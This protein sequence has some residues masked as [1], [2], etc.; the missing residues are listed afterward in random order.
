MKF[1]AEK[2][3]IEK[4]ILPVSIVSQNK[5]SEAS[6]DGIFIK[7]ENDNVDFFCYDLEKGIKTNMEAFVAAPGS[8]VS[9][10]QLVPIIH[11]MPDGEIT[12]SSDDNFI[13]TISCGETQVQILG[14]D[15]EKYPDMPQVKGDISFT[16]TQKQL[17]NL[18]TKTCFSLSKDDSNPLLRGSYFEIKENILTVSSIDGFRC[19]VRTEKS[20]TECP[21]VDITF[22]LPGKAQTNLLKIQ[23]ENYD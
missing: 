18:I 20:M 12:I 2:K 5:S 10:S 16:L 22:I 6:N 4:T 21:N 9:D 8:I 15:S 13:I 14:K 3:V 23:E 19:A 1:T 7:A 11:S 17:R